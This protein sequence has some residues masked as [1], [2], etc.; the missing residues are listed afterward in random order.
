MPECRCPN[1]KTYFLAPSSIFG[2]QYKCETCK[3]EFKLDIIHL[4]RFQLP[5]KIRIQLRNS[6]GSSF[7][8]FSVPVMI[9]YGFSLPPLLSDSLGRLLITREMF[10]KA[11]ADEISTGLM[12]HKGDYSLVRYINI[13][14]PSINDA[15]KLSEQRA[16][17][18]WP[19]LS[20]EQELYGD[21]SNLLASY[22]PEEDIEPVSTKIDLSK[23]ND[24]VELEIFLV[25]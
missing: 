18:G 22:I 11:Q 13:S 3:S 10:D 5:Y 24:A 6:D 20:F 23:E 16:N 19:I 7:T 17:S 2:F 25:Q 15:K 21:M 14:I 9:Q 4:A 8:K 1:C 12:D